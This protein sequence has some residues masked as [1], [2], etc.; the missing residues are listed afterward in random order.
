MDMDPTGSSTL[1]SRLGSMVLPDVTGSRGIVAGTRMHK[2]DPTGTLPSR[3]EAGVWPDPEAL[4]PDPECIKWIWIRPDPQHCRLD[5]RR[6][7]GQ[8]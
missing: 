1:P 8:M 5:W 6:G 2:M 4:L 3:L 7:F